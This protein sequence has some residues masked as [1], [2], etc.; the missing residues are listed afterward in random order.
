MPGQ[1]SD[2]PGHDPDRW[3]ADNHARLVEL[4]QDDI[5]PVAQVSNGREADLPQPAGRHAHRLA[6]QTSFCR[7][8]SELLHGEAACFRRELAA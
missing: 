8:R 5:V 6:R 2:R 1:E 3:V 7:Q 4:V